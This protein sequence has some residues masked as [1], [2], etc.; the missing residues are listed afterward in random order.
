MLKG[1]LMPAP[2]NTKRINQEHEQTEL[3]TAP[4]VI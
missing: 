1:E 4:D 2:L 3:T